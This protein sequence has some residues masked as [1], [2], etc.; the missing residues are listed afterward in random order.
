MATEDMRERL[1]QL[2]HHAAVAFAA[3]CARRV[4]PLTHALPQQGRDAID[5]ASESAEAFAKGTADAAADAAAARADAARADA[6]RADAEAAVAAKAAG[7]ARAGAEAAWADAAD[8]ARADAAGAAAAWAAAAALVA[9]AAAAD[10]AAAWAAA[11][12]DLDRLIAL[13]RGE[14]DT[15][16]APIDQSEAG[17]LGPLW[18]QGMPEWYTQAATGTVTPHEEP[19][20]DAD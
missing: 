10:E 20:G 14:P 15:L 4:Q 7:A 19:S 8:V 2:P 18:P 11:S 6:A 13:K 16:G 12:S 5:R 1:A 17:P 9:G 3:R